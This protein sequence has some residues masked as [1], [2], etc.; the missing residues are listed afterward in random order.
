[1]PDLISMV[2]ITIAQVFFDSLLRKA[3]G[4]HD[5]ST[6]QLM[7]AAAGAGFIASPF[8]S[9]AEMIMLMQQKY[10]ISF[11]KAIHFHYSQLGWKGILR[12]L[13]VCSIRDSVYTTAYL[14]FA[15]W[16]NETCRNRFSEYPTLAKFNHWLP[17]VIAG[18]TG[19]LA[20]GIVTQPLDCIKSRQQASLDRK[21]VIDA[22]REIFREDGYKGFFTGMKG[23]LQRV[24]FGVIVLS[25]INDKMQRWLRY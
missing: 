16:L 24:S 11:R 14:G 4:T 20:A 23:R 19:G 5:L 15:P 17:F 8:P 1:M 21:S 10:S 22:S 3:M 25:F 12:G 2:P 6:A 18:P 13:P 9:Y 7:F